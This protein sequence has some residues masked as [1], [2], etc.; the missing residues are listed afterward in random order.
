[1]RAVIGSSPI[2]PTIYSDVHLSRLDFGA[3]VPDLC[4]CLTFL[5]KHV[6]EKKEKEKTKTYSCSLYKLYCSASRARSSRLAM[7]DFSYGIECVLVYI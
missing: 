1:M 7:F 6:Y 5:R 3:S 4:L 2:I